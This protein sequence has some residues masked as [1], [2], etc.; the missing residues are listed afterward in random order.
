MHGDG[1]RWIRESP[2]GVH[3]STMHCGAARHRAHAPLPAGIVAVAAPGRLLTYLELARL[4]ASREVKA[5]DDGR[6][7]RTGGAPQCR[8]TACRV[9]GATACRVRGATACRGGT[10]EER[11]AAN[12][13]VST[14]SR[15]GARPAPS[16][17]TSAGTRHDGRADD[18]PRRLACVS[19]EHDPTWCG[20]TAECAHR[21]AAGA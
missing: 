13:H 20:R 8:D 16:A 21:Q 7:R 1:S 6:R 3:P 11:N 12:A 14:A 4:F 17:W 15:Y 9:R 10:E 5:L 2:S 19:D 18:V